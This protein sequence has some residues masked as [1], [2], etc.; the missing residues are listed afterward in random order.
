MGRALSLNGRGEK[1]SRWLLQND[2]DFRLQNRSHLVSVSAVDQAGN[3]ARSAIFR[4]LLP[5]EEDHERSGVDRFD[6]PA[7]GK[8][9]LPGS[10]IAGYPIFEDKGSIL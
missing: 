7:P 10:G 4:D 3:Q 2:E 6:F 5:V 8:R 9:I 1:N